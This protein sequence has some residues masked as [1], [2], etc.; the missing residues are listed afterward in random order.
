MLSSHTQNEKPFPAMFSCE[1]QTE[2]ETE[3]QCLRKSDQLVWFALKLTQ[4]SEQ[5]VVIE[6]YFAEL[7]PC[8]LATGVVYTRTYTK[9]EMCN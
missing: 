6:T 1:S 4:D 7:G 8:D 9:S 2:A 3:Q 5:K